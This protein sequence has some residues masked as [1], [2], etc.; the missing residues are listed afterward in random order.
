MAVNYQ[1]IF[2]ALETPNEIIP[3]A[4]SGGL[5]QRDPHLVIPSEWIMIFQ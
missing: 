2:F 3:H 4:A 1:L 5:L